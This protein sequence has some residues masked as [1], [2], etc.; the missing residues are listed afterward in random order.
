MLVLRED[1]IALISFLAGK[2]ASGYIGRTALMKYLY[3]L[4]IL[5]N[6]PLAYRFTLY[7][8][9]PFDSEVLADLAGAEALDAVTSELELY[10][11]GY[12]YKIKPGTKAKGV[13]KK[14]AKFLKQH[15]KDVTWVVEHF[16]QYKSS[17]ELE[18]LGTI[19]YVDR[20]AHGQRKKPKLSELAR[21]VHEIKPHFSEKKILDLAR[22][23][24][25]E[26]LLK[27]AA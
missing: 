12:G 3:F 8:Y 11:G 6:V 20:E 27:S 13:E 18:L 16:G 7:S 19:I 14:A 25:K 17:A 1:R 10:S 26:D 22:K 9:G 15:D 21:N 2:S 24:A 23:L 4:Q 5:R